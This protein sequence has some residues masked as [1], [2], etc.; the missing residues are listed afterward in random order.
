MLLLGADTV[1]QHLSFDELLD[2]LSVGFVELSSGVADAPPPA[3]A[4]SEAGEF[5][6]ALPAITTG[7][8]A[9]KL[10]S[11]F[12]ENAARGVPSHQGVVVLFDSVTGSPLALMDARHITA[13]R[14]AA[15]TA[16][17]TR[18]LL[19]G[20][21]TTLAIIGAG[22]QGNSHLA[23]LT[24]VADF[25]EIR[26]AARNH[27]SAETLAAGHPQARAVEGVE[28]AVRGAD[29]ICLCTSSMTPVIERDW[30][31]TGAHVNSV[32]FSSGPEVDAATMD[33]ARIFVESRGRSFRAPPLGAHELVG[34]RAGDAVE[35]GEVLAGTAPGRLAPEQIT[36]FK[37]AGNAIGDA[38][39]AAVI[40]RN[41]VASGAGTRWSP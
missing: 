8:V 39:A 31:R 33:E 27:E 6:M 17:A 30:V 13:I 14:T 16:L 41:A 1:R 10:I 40:Y 4:T 5:L 19:P 37:S 23:A 38:A 18:M 35:L 26:V 12:H 2:E 29:V 25:E 34:R 15:T 21:A 11:V 32:G 24:A 20:R 7:T 3:I 22:V 36:V 9:A 28:A